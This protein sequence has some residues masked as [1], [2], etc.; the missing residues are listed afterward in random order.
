VTGAE[1]ARRA[2]LGG[3]ILLG[4]A[5]LGAAALGIEWP[6]VPALLRD[7]WVQVLLLSLG[8]LVL[9]AALILLAQRPSATPPPVVELAAAE[10]STSGSSLL[11]LPALTEEP[12]PDP[13]P[14]PLDVPV[15]LPS[16]SDLRPTGLAASE[17]VPAGSGGSTLLIPFADT[18]SPP[19]P[20]P[21]VPA[22][23]GSVARLVDRMEDLRQAHPARP[24]PPLSSPFSATGTIASPLLLRLTRI[25]GP[26]VG[27]GPVQVARRCSDCGE[28]LGS[29]PH[30]EPCGGCGQ[31]LCGRC[32]WRTPSGPQAHLCT[33]C[34]ADRSVPRSPTPGSIFPRPTAVVSSSAPSPTNGPRLRRAR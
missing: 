5:L 14:S 24:S 1:S 29:P 8:A 15:D 2:R 10:L 28:P 13:T 27:S 9:S 23:R 6:P 33:T 30:F 16:S 20:E 4:A 17:Q 25:P 32:Y 19:T 12:P 34:F 18:P 7:P 31:A 11:A 26:P 22:S 3:W 21:S